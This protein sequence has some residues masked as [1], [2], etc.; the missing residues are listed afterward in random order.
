MPEGYEPDYWREEES[1][2]SDGDERIINHY[3]RLLSDK[4]LTV[5]NFLGG[6][7][8]REE[9]L[10]RFKNGD[11]DVLLAMKCL[12]EGVNIPR[13]EYAIFCASTGNPRQFIQRRGRVL[14]T[15]DFKRKAKIFD[16]IVAP[17][18]ESY[19]VL[20]QKQ[21]DAEKLIFR[22]EIHRVVNFLSL[23]DNRLELVDGVFGQTCREYGVTDLKGLMNQELRSY[24][25]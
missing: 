13:T 19:E 6:T 9:V 10:N 22:N 12:D 5:K 18:F 3:S 11:Y 20:D 7:K 8:G 14:R 16:L 23:A 24:E 15:H 2:I 17:D 21:I 4:G 1:Q 25:D